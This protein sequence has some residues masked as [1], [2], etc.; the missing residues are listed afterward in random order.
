ML[1]QLCYSPLVSMLFH[2][3]K[4]DEMPEEVH[5]LF[6]TTVKSSHNV[7][8]V[9]ALEKLLKLSNECPNRFR[10]YLFLSGHVS[11]TLMEG[12][13]PRQRFEPRKM[14]DG[15]VI[16]AFGNAELKA[17]TVCYICGPLQMTDHFAR[18]VQVQV[19]LEP[20]QVF[21][22]ECG[23]AETSSTVGDSLDNVL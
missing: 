17:S 21:Y 4:T 5:F 2:M 6:T 8:N 13:M 9:L 14:L 20:D 3:Y 23:V 22:Q 12:A 7:S 10:L 1:M 15:D 18:L 11:R 16:G 19:G